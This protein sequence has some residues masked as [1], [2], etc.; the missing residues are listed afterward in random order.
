[1]WEAKADATGEG[2]APEAPEE[3]EVDEAVEAIGEGAAV[4]EET[5]ELPVDEEGN[6]GEA[7]EPDEMHDKAVGKFK[8]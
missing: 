7:E 1:M 2:P 6:I 4:E 3:E 5:L 8:T